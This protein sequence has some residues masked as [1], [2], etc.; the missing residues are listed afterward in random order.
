MASGDEQLQTPINKLSPTL[1]L[2]FFGS[3]L[4]FHA[5]GTVDG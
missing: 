5:F 2:H 3:Y 4:E 1:G